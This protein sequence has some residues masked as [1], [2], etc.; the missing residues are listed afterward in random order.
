[1]F[2]YGNSG[3]LILVIC[4]STFICL[5]IFHC[6]QIIQLSYTLGATL[7]GCREWRFDNKK[8]V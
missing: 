3:Q 5:L 4:W 7:F 8:R 6:Q 1:M 2:V